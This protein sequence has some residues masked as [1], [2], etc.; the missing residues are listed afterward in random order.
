MMAQRTITCPN[1]GHAC[2]AEESA[3]R[4]PHCGMPCTPAA[5]AESEDAPAARAHIGCS[6]LLALM[7]LLSFIVIG[8]GFI[9]TGDGNTRF[10]GVM[11]L[12]L[13]AWTVF[14]N[15]RTGKP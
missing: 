1:C 5:P 14:I 13:A 9:V 7:V 4:C 6:A 11:F 8:I 15:T 10:M 3:P 12:L 2:P